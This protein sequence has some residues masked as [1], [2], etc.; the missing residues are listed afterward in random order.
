METMK[1]ETIDRY[2]EKWLPLLQEGAQDP[3]RTLSLLIREVERD[4][5]HAAC[6]LVNRLHTEISNLD[7]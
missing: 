4:T 1:K 3:R 6:D 2:I 5:R 7:H